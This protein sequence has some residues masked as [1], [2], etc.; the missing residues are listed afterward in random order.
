MA[1]TLETDRLLLRE[2]QEEDF[3]PYHAMNNDP[4]VCAFFP[5]LQTEEQSRSVIA[6]YREQDR[7]DGFS[8]Q[9]LIER[10]SGAFI[11]DIGLARVEFDAGFKGAVEIGWMMQRHH[12]GKGYAT[13]MARALLDYAFRA[14]RL[15]EVLAFTVPA[16]TRSRLVMER[17][18]MK[19]DTAAGFDHP[20]IAAGHPLRPHVLYRTTAPASRNTNA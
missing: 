13:E 4:E 11:G 9:P 3:I 10:A 2:W 12:W 1:L 5:N 17:L 15:P 6:R 7:R 19:Q 16:N 14:L 18:G 8:F 20:H